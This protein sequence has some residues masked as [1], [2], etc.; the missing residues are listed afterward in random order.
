MNDTNDSNDFIQAEYG[1]TSQNLTFPNATVNDIQGVSLPIITTQPV[2]IESIVDGEQKAFPW[3]FPYGENGLST[4]RQSK[5]SQIK[6]KRKK[7]FKLNLFV[8]KYR[9]PL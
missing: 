6:K 1:T 5:L 7:R 2:N 9:R 8:Q 3:L 4:P